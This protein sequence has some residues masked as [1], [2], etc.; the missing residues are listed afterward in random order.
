MVHFIQNGVLIDGEEF[1]KTTARY[2]G[3]MTFEEGYKRTGRH[4]NIT[5][6]ASS[7]T[8]QSGGSYKSPHSPLLSQPF[9]SHFHTQRSPFHTVSSTVPSLHIHMH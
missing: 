8:M 1:E 7:A 5:I 9:H 4:V 2:Y 6:S 3:D